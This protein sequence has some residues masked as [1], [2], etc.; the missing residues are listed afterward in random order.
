MV[1]LARRIWLRRNKLVF[2][3]AFI[4]PS[5][6]FKEAVEAIEEY[7]KWPKRRFSKSSPG[8]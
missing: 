2:E 1:G 8:G 7:K 6:V 5:L 4:P 3:G